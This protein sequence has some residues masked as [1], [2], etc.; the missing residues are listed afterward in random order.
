[1]SSINQLGSPNNNFVMRKSYSSKHLKKLKAGVPSNIEFPIDY[2]KGED[3]I[4]SVKHDK[5]SKQVLAV[6]DTV[7]DKMFYEAG[8]YLEPVT[9]NGFLKFLP[10]DCMHL[11]DS[12]YHAVHSVS[13]DDKSC[14]YYQVNLNE[15]QLTKKGREVLSELKK[16]NYSFQIDM[17]SCGEDGY[18]LS[19]SLG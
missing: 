6:I 15:D 14:A 18:V 19:A 4:F 2:R 8:L 13:Y 1:M 9:T 10:G 5:V 3:E 7:A 17:G 16:S 11:V 12:L